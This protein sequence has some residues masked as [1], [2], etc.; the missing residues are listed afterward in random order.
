MRRHEV[1]VFSL[2]IGLL[3]VGTALIW[4]LSDDP[5][6]YVEGWPMPTLLIVVGVVGLVAGLTRTRGS[7]RS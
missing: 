1:D 4:G 6:G 7:D 3:F 2:V 5:G